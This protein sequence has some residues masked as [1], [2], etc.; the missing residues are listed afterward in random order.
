LKIEF[1]ERI[2][3]S[4]DEIFWEKYT[5]LSLNLSKVG[6]IDDFSFP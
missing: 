1:N 2:V 6:V 3:P 5:P 4:A